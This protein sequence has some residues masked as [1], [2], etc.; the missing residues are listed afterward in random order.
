MNIQHIHERYF[1]EDDYCCEC[2]TALSRHERFLCNDCYENMNAI[3][4]QDFYD[5]WG[6]DWDIPLEETGKP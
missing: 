2:G 4:E 5:G 3:E 1:E 6:S